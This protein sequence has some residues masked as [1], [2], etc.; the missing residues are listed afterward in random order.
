VHTRGAALAPVAQLDTDRRRWV[1]AGRDGDELAELVVDEVNAHTMGAQTRSVSWREIEVELGRGG[2]VA[3]LDRIEQRLLDVGARR[4]ASSSKLGRV[5]AERLAVVSGGRP[6]AVKRG[7]AG[8]EVL[9]ALR[10]QAA[11][12]RAQDPA[13]RREVPD[14]V[15]QMRVAA[16]RMRSTLRAFGRVL[17]RERTRELAD[18]LKWLG[19]E[20]ADSRDGEVLEERLTAV[21]G[22]LPD[23]LVLGPVGAHVTRTLAR[24]RAEGD[25]RALAALGSERYLALQTRIDALLDE[26]PLTRHARRKAAKELPRSVGKAY[27]RTDQRV[28]AALG[29]QDGEQRDLLLHEARKAAK[30]AR[31]A[32]EVAEPSVGKPAARFRRAFK[33]VQQ[34]LGDHQ[35]AAVARPVLR[36]LAGSAHTEGGNG[37]S[38]GLLYAR[39]ERRAEDAERALPKTW[40][41][42]AKKKNT[43]WLRG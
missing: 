43:G 1:L 14:S 26:P 8:A 29:E 10:D 33:G 3:V 36:E 34:L 18:E 24:R 30:R 2:E 7:S 32:A 17:D 20:L 5:L 42:V 39:E 35:D 6:P 16:R 22:E 38:F 28:R 25:A 21:V 23:E 4:S 12:L 27:R 11:V 15:H 19:G 13:V 37:F 41:R 40:H 9:A 31:Y